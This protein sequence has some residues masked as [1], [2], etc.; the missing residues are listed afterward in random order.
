MGGGAVFQVHRRHD[1]ADNPTSKGS[2]APTDS[3]WLVKR[4][5]HNHRV[6]QTKLDNVVV[7]DRFVYGLSDGILQCV[8]LSTG[9]RNW[10]GDDYG[11]GQL[12]R[13]GDLLLI[14]G[15]TGEVALVALNPDSFKQ[16]AKFQALEG[17][18]WNN[19]ALSGN[20]L[21]VRN[22]QQAAAYELPLSP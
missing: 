2:S 16:L 6:L 14:T 9:N 4:L 19:P 10:A 22:A 5:W 3:D 11:H 12:L 7:K 1:S 8:D 21:L 18:T 17:K 15:E 20:L 13:I